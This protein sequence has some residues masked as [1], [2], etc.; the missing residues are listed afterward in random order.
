MLKLSNVDCGYE[1]LTVVKNVSFDLNEGQ[2]LCLLGSSGCGKTTLLRAIAGFNPLHNG[3]IKLDG[4]L[5]CSKTKSIPPE[6][7]QIGMVFQD[8]ALFPHL[9][10]FDNIAFGLHK[11]DKQKR[12]ERIM[13][14]LA[15]IDLHDYAQKFPHELSG[16]QQQRVA[17][18]RA[19]APK[20]KVILLDEP[21][22]NLD[23]DRR[24]QLAG[25]VKYILKQENTAAILV[26]HDQE[27]A[28]LMADQVALLTQSTDIKDS[29]LQLGSAQTLYSYPNSIEVAQFFGDGVF[30]DIEINKQSFELFHQ[31]YQ[32]NQSLKD[33]AYQILIR[34]QN[35]NFNENGNIEFNIQNKQ[36]HGW[37]DD[38]T[39]CVGQTE[40]KIQLPQSISQ[41]LKIGQQS[42]A[43]FAPNDKWIY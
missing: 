32:I 13:D 24:R 29:I 35:L 18:A 6:N 21:F 15:L 1:A 9:S 23:L 37:Y 11:Q 22:S 39:L 36:F 42:K 3:E 12:F 19:L 43:F 25:E 7:R 30:L 38:V 27:E 33:G 34:S 4:A 26:T 16:G 8:Y 40:I 5:I 10:I 41:N 14:L 31:N 2:I 17:L 28:F 20:P